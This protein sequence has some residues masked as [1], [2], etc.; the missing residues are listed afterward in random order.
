MNTLQIKNSIAT[1]LK[2]FNSG[3][4]KDNAIAFFNMAKL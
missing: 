1:A 4:I 2:N 3:A